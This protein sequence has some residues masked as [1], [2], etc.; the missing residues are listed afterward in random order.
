[1]LVITY[2]YQELDLGVEVH[3]PCYFKPY[4]LDGFQMVPV[5][6]IQSWFPDL[7]TRNH[8]LPQGGGLEIDSI[9]VFSGFPGFQGPTLESNFGS[10]LDSWNLKRYNVC[11]LSPSCIFLFSLHNYCTC[12]FQGQRC[13]ACLHC[14]LR[15]IVRWFLHVPEMHIIWCPGFFSPL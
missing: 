4:S 15:T 14:W 11:L 3:N 7:K 10:E 12:I 5:W 2:N 1:M 13:D 6:V 9:V 8:G